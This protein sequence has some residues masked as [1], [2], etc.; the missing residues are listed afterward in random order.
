M[1][2][3]KAENIASG[4]SINMGNGWETKEEEVKGVTG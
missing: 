2:F 4:K 1:A 3:G